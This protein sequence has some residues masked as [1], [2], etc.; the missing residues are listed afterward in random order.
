MRGADA[1]VAPAYR[2]KS[3]APPRAWGGPEVGGLG[4]VDPRSTPTCVGRT[5]AGQT[6]R[7]CK[8]EHPHV[9]GADLGWLATAWMEHGAPPRAWGGQGR[10][11]ARHLPE[12]S[13][14]TCVG[15]TTHAQLARLPETEH[16]HV[17]GADVTPTIHDSRPTGAP[18][19]AWGGPRPRA[20]RLHRRRSTPTCVGRTW[21]SPAGTASPPEYPH[22]RGADRAG[23]SSPA[24]GSGAPPR[25][26][27]GHFA[28]C[29]FTEQVVS[30][31]GAVSPVG[32]PSGGG[33]QGVRV[34]IVAS[35][36][37]PEESGGVDGG[38]GHA[39][40]G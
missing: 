32:C 15:R 3:G 2:R 16:P 20:L 22:V 24:A 13:T 34:S 31:Q 40:V 37:L 11:E 5:G 19:R 33:C 26:W 1:I 8:P 7:T 10:D 18:P 23:A 6:L 39:A 35:Q 28:T 21:L 38:A 9:R 36:V 14:P 29:G 17:R 27:G 25:A 12:R 30:F 4:I